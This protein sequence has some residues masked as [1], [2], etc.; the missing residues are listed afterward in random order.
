MSWKRLYGEAA[1]KFEKDIGKSSPIIVGFNANIDAVKYLNKEFIDWL[2]FNTRKK[3][4]I[5]NLEDL[6]RGIM[7]SV[8]S[9]EAN[10]WEVGNSLVYHKVLEHGFDEQRIGGQAGIVANLMGRIGVKTTVLLPSL[11]EKQAKFFTNKNVRIAVPTSNSLSLKKPSGAGKKGAPTRINCIFEFKKGF[12][13]SPRA[14]RFILSYHPKECK[15]ILDEKLILYSKKYLKSVRRVFLSGYQLLESRNDFSKAKTQLEFMREFSKKAKY[16]MELTNV[17]E[18]DKRKGILGIAKNFDSLGCNEVE[19]ELYTGTNQIFDGMKKLVQKTG[20][21]RLHFHNLYN[22]F[23]LLSKDYDVPVEKVRMGMM[24][25]ALMSS[26]KASRGE[27]KSR[28][29]VSKA[30]INV[31]SKGLKY[32]KDIDNEQG[33]IHMNNYTMIIIPNLF[34]NKVKSTVG[35]GDSIS[36]TAFVGETV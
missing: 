30:R 9:G 33:I 36:A 34:T 5:D 6:G 26:A 27:V 19:L 4:E 10:E 1:K 11:S 22:H 20:V 12:M 13:K 7:E 23:C 29:E 21:E 3:Q 25:G 16:H 17:E 18:S 32:L 2:G 28:K 31:S 15:P 24:M 35:L 8:D 14:N